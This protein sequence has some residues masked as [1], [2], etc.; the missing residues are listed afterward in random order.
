MYIAHFRLFC[1]VSMFFTSS[2]FF[3]LSFDF[4]LIF[5]VLLS[6]PLC[7]AINVAAPPR[8]PMV[9]GLGKIMVTAT[10]PAT[11]TN[12]SSAFPNTL[13]LSFL[14]SFFMLL[15]VLL[16]ASLSFRISSSG[17]GMSFIIYNIKCYLRLDMF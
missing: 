2:L 4:S 13:S 11:T 16:I 15:R 1:S 17:L 9:M 7:P 6:M 8:T 5:L 12:A 10:P 3:F 14:M